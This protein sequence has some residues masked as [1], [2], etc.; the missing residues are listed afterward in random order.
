MAKQQLQCVQELQ[1]L[2][3]RVLYNHQ[4]ERGP[5]GNGPFWRSPLLRKWLG[6]EFF[7]DPAYVEIG[8]APADARVRSAVPFL[9]QLRKPFMLR[10]FWCALSDEGAKSIKDISNLE[11]LDIGDNRLTTA[12]LSELH[13]LPSLKGLSLNNCDNLDDDAVQYLQQLPQLQLL[14]I[15]GANL[16]GKAVRELKMNLPNCKVVSKGPAWQ[17]GHLDD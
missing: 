5:D 10:T 6:D 9:R 8:A 11:S 1:K 16:S 17:T 2:G 7:D 3:Y 13:S 15:I 12:G 4:A 14:G